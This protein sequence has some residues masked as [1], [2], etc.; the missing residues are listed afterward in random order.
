MAGTGNDRPG[1]EPEER[2]TDSLWRA[3]TVFGWL[4]AATAVLSTAWVLW[5]W[6]TGGLDG[7]GPSFG[8]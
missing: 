4:M 1:Q 2:R 5:L 6:A 8:P 7:T 3:F